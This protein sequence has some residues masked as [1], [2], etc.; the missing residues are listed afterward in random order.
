MQTGAEKFAYAPPEGVKGTWQ[1][2]S[3]PYITL[4]ACKEELL[5]VCQ[6]WILQAEH[7]VIHMK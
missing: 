3:E 5:S 6:F 1:L 7:P 4:N 2:T